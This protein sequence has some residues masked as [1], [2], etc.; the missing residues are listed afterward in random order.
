MRFVSGA[1]MNIHMADS[2]EDLVFIESVWF[3]PAV[4]RWINDDLT[5][6]EHVDF[7][8]IVARGLFFLPVFDDG[9]KM[10]FFYFVPWNNVCWEVHSAIIPEFRGKKAIA[11]SKLMAQ[12]FFANMPYA[13]KIVTHVPVDNQKAYAYAVRTGFTKEGMNRKSI[14]RDGNLVDQYLFGLC[15]EEVICQ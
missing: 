2:L 10:G 7:S 8:K 15:K 4:F 12:W 5:K 6:T 1:I 9:R 13:S 11:A 3:N 14:L